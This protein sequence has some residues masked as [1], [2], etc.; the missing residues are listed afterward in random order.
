MFLTHRP[1]VHR[2]L[3]VDRPGIQAVH[4]PVRLPQWERC[5]LGASACAR[6]D[7][8]EDVALEHRHRQVPEGEAAQKLAGRAEYQVP[9]Q[10]ARH[11]PAEVPSVAS[12]PAEP[13]QQQHPLGSSEQ[14]PSLQAQEEP[15]KP[16]QHSSVLLSS[17]RT[18]PPPQSWAQQEP[19]P[20]ALEQ[21]LLPGV[22]PPPHLLEAC[23]QSQ[24]AELS[25][26][27]RAS[28]AAQSFSAQVPRS[29]ESP[30]APAELPLAAR[31][32]PSEKSP[33]SQLVLNSQG[34]LYR[35]WRSPEPT[36]QAHPAAQAS[37]LE[38]RSALPQL[39]A[40]RAAAGSSP[41]PPVACVR[42]S[43]SAHR[44]ASK[45]VTN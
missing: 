12:P 11:T 23:S 3:A 22:W 8:S 31:C 21:P 20:Q 28:A 2:I 43:P 9:G 29:P 10:Q 25:L 42:G 16:P 15:P 38:L 7:P 37:Q 39:R 19:A 6:L 44:P 18:S 33:H 32:S 27:P 36:P 30:S 34:S 5:A 1:V 24:A 40:S 13:V 26:E 41:A 35:V 45:C 17:A 14:Q 4:H